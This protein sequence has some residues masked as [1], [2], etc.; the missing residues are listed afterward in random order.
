MWLCVVVCRTK[1]AIFLLPC[2]E[3]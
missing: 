1:L 2:S 3:G